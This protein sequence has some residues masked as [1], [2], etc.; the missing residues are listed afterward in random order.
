MPSVRSSDELRLAAISH[1]DLA[2]VVRIH[3]RAFPDG[4]LT[5]FGP[6]TLERYYAW[7]L[8]GPH[9]AAV[10]GA[11]RGDRLVGF[12]AAGWFRGAMN[13]FLR[14]NRWFLARHVLTHPS[15]LAAPLIRERLR[16]ALA[17]TVR[18]SRLR[19]QP[20]ATPDQGRRFGVLSIATDPDVRGSGAGRALM[21]DAEERARAQ[22]HHAMVLTVHPENAR[23]V[24]FYEQL[25]WQRALEPDGTWAGRMDKAI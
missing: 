13:G 5:V 25:G 7:L 18:Y 6:R 10:I 16:Q 1:T 3:E 12:C 24:S 21:I 4:A 9:E 8:D 15:L 14:A 23:A 22:G 17:I 19:A 2:A 20:A 11:W